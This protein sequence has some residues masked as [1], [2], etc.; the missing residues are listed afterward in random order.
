MPLPK[1]RKDQ[2]LKE[3]TQTFM[4]N[5]E[6]VKDFPDS[7]QRYAVMMQTY[8]DHLKESIG[9]EGFIDPNRNANRNTKK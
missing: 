6:M 9:S 7:K 5:P 4:S 2:D 1:P 8:K 3:F